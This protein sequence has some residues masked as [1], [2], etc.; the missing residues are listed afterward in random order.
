MLHIRIHHGLFLAE[1]GL[2][3]GGGLLR[4][5][6]L[7]LGGGGIGGRLLVVAAGGQD[8]SRH[9]QSGRGYRARRSHMVHSGH[10]FSAASTPNTGRAVPLPVSTTSA[11]PPAP[12]ISSRRSIPTDTTTNSPPTRHSPLCPRRGRHP[13]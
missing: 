13:P 9:G 12:R 8:E 1:L 7:R 6:G 10:Q 5:G 2:G 3:G 4:G 11:I